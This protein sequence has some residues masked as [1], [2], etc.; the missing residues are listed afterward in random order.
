MFHMSR[1]MCHVS[2]VKWRMSH[3]K[4]LNWSVEGLLSTGLPRLAL[5]HLNNVSPYSNRVGKPKMALS[6]NTKGW[7]Y[8]VFLQ[9]EI[10]DTIHSIHP[11]VGITA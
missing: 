7:N 10:K 4:W 11:I 3:F 9:M 5:I 6:V 1:V 2:H 8:L